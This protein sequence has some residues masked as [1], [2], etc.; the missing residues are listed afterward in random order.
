[1]KNVVD[2]KLK[3]S[4]VSSIGEGKFIIQTLCEKNNIK[5]KHIEDID[6]HIVKIN[7]NHKIYINLPSALV[8]LNSIG[9]I[10]EKT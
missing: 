6:S 9:Q 4:M 5:Y 1:M 7:K 10:H 2:I 8:V 3:N